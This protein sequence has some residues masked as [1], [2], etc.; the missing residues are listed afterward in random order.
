MELREEILHYIVK[1]ELQQGRSTS[2]IFKQFDTE[3][4]KALHKSRKF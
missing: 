1:R 2:D 4:Y 3:C